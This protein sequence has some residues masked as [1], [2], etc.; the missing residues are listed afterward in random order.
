MGAP[1]RFIDWFADTPDDLSRDSQRRTDGGNRRDRAVHPAGQ[2]K[3][4]NERGVLR[5]MRLVVL[6]PSE[7]YKTQAGAR[8]RYGRVSAKLAARGVAISLQH[9]AEFKADLAECDGILLSK[10]YDARAF[11]AA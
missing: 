6:V 7:Q 9:I 11:V 4:S 1:V 3:P 2:I 8:I 5:R 10:C